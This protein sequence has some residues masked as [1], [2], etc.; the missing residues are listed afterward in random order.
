MQTPKDVVVLSDSEGV[1]LLTE[2]LTPKAGSVAWY[3]NVE[4][5]IH[6]QSLS[7]IAV[8]V[9]HAR[10]QPNGVLLATLGRMN[11]EY[12][13]MQKVAVMEE[14]PSLSV[15]RYM[16]ACGVDLIWTGSQ[17]ESID[18]LAAVVDRMYERTAWIVS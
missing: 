5:L 7:S 9:V 18:Q 1:H 10:P 16:A 12:P 4:D 14:A 15:A 3:A 13:A 17:N 8:L 11:V 2:R 6:A